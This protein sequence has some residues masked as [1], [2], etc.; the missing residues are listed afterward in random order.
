VVPTTP[1][2]PCLCVISMNPV[3]TMTNIPAA[4][5]PRTGT[6]VPILQVNAGVDYSPGQAG[7][8]RLLLRFYRATAGEV[9]T[10]SNLSTCDV[11]GEIGIPY[12]PKG[13]TLT[14]DGR[15]QLAT[16]TCADGTVETPVLFTSVGP[17]AQWPVL[18]CADAWCVAVT[19]DGDNVA[20]DAWA[21]VS[22]AVRDDVW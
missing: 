5:L 14:I 18:G 16:V 17:M 1:N 8:R 7:M 15:Q 2:D 6:F 19:A 20:D 4:T 11:M 13:A 9:C 3:T 12:L 10:Y 21:S 22:V